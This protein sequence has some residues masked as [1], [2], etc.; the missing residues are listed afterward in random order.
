MVELS[1]NDIIDEWF[2]DNHEVHVGRKGY[3]SR[4]IPAPKQEEKLTHLISV[5]H[6]YG[7]SK[8]D[9]LTRQVIN[10]VV[11]VAT[12]REWYSSSGLRKWKDVTAD[13]WKLFVVSFFK[14][15][16][17]EQEQKEG[18][19]LSVLK[20]EDLG[21]ALENT[22]EEYVPSKPE[23]RP[24]TEPTEDPEESDIQAYK[25]GVPLDRS[26][27][28]DLPPQVVTLDE[29]F[30]KEIGVDPNFGAFSE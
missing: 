12:P 24:E 28:K 9:M 7:V 23:D 27:F 22:V 18:K 5:L 20:K 16:R 30:L 2:I 14:D 29:D 4:V 8:D 15:L 11:A 26:L 13:N 1:V 25:E 6:G 17:D 10:K 21:P 3:S 19:K